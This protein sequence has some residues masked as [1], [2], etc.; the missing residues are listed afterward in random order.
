MS[1]SVSAPVP[2]RRR[3]RIWPY[4][5]GTLVLAIIL[6]VLFWNWD[7]FIPIVDA[8]ASAAIGRRVIVVHAFVKS[9][10]RRQGR[11]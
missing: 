4:V 5:L 2:A 6:L 3:R 9:P 1:T 11:P 7:W 10:R 8:R